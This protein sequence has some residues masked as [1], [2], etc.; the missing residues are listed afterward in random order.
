[1]PDKSKH[2]AR[3]ANFTDNFILKNLP[4]ADFAH[5]LPDLEKIHLTLGQVLYEAEDRIDYLYFPDHSMISAIATTAKGESAE[6]G[7]IGREGIGGI[8][9]LLGSE[10]ATNRHII[11]LP[12]GAHRIKP[13]AALKEFKRFGAF[14]DLALGFIRLMMVQISQTAL[15]N[16]LHS[17]EER[18][19]KWL[20]LCHDRARGNKL[21][22]TQEFLSIMLG[23]NRPTVTVSAIVLQGAGFIKYAR[24]MITVLDREGLEDFSCACYRNI[25]KEYDRFQQ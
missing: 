12:D 13:A 20:L 1:M 14:H 24:G 4:E 3:P 19:A 6:V 15:C 8:D 10:T 2:A 25:K 7:V 9:L 5:L 16:R 21:P 17:V 22:L 23:A 18:L 11:Q